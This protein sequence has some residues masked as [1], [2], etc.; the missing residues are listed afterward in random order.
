MVKE[1]TQKHKKAFNDS[2]THPLQSWEWGG[3]RSQAGNIVRR[4]G[5]FKNNR[6]VTPIQLTIHKIPGSPFKV[7]T[8]IKGSALD[9]EILDFLKDFAKKEN[10]IFIKM[11]PNIVISKNP[12]KMKE[13][14]KL[15][16]KNSAK[17]GKHL[18]TP[19][20]FWI[21]LKLSEDELMKSFSSKTRY[22]IRVALRHGV[23]VR[24]DNSPE[25]FDRYIELTRETAVRQKFFA[26]TE[27]YHRLMWQT[28]HRSRVKTKE[29]PIAHLLTARYKKKIITT[30]ILFEWNGFLYYPYGASTDKYKDVMANNLMLWE[31]IKFGKKHKLDTFDLWG[32]EPGKGFTRFKEGYSPEVVEFIGTWDLVT[33]PFYLPYIYADKLRWLYLRTRAK[34][35]NIKPQ[36]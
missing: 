11:E 17:E 8:F 26:H 12:I 16:K 15:L 7:A 18:F 3:F 36:F 23:E 5:Q 25:A 31:A 24:E 35:S 32:R 10:I 34:L 4:F 21:N 20:T 28:L 6:L 30:W 14:I 1:V 19:S 9:D 29:K 13:L 27:R 22:N 33:S 2:S